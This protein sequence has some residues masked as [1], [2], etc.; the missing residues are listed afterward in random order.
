MIILYELIDFIRVIRN[1]MFALNAEV[2]FD[3]FGK[4]LRFVGICRRGAVLDS[5][6]DQGLRK[7]LIL[8]QDSLGSLSKLTELQNFSQLASPPTTGRG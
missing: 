6:A 1:K 2:S 5:R 4:E 7:F 8:R 3:R